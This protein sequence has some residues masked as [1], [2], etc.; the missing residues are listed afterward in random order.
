[1]IKFKLYVLLLLATFL[2]F[3]CSKYDDT[4][5]RKDV[6]D[7]Q[8]RVQ[9]LEK[10]C[11][12]ANGQIASLQGLVTALQNNDYVTGVTPVME[13]TEEVGYTLSFTQSKPI[14][15]M[16]GKNGKDG[17]TPII[18]VKMYTDN[19]YYW[20]IQTGNDKADWMKDDDGNMIPTTGKDG[21]AGQTPVLSV[22]K[23]GDRY[24]WQIDGEW[25]KDENGQKVPATGDKGDTGPAGSDGEQGAPGEKGDSFFESV[26]PDTSNGTVMIKLA[27][28]TEFTLPMLS[29]T[30]SFEAYTPLQI[31][32]AETKTA[33]IVKLPATIKKADFAAIKADITNLAGTNTAI[34]RTEAEKWT[35]ALT[36]PTFK[37]DGTLDAQPT[38]NVTVPATAVAGETALLEVAVVDTKGNKTSSTRV[39]YYDNNIAVTSVTLDPPTTIVKVGKTET[40]TATVTPANATNKKIIWTS[41]DAAVA[42]VAEGVVTG[43]KAGTATITATTEDGNFTA[44]CAVTVENIA[45]E[46]ISL[47]NTAIFLNEKKNI[48]YTIS[49]TDATVKTLIWSSSDPTIATVNTSTGEIEGKN[50]GDVTITATWT[51]DSRI[52]GTCTV[53]VTEKTGIVWATGNLV[54][55]GANGA[56]IGSPADGGLYFQFGSLIGWSGSANEDGTGI[57]G[58][59][60][61][62]VV[63]K[64]IGYAGSTDWGNTD[65][66]WQ[67]K[68]ATV[69]FT[70]AGSGSAEEIAGVG[71]PCRYYLKGNWRLPT[72]EDFVELFKE[73]GYPN[74]GPWKWNATT[75]SIYN[76]DGLTFP[77]SGNRNYVS[78]GLGTIG[79]SG[80]YWSATPLTSINNSSSLFFSN[81]NVNTSVSFERLNGLPIR[82]VQDK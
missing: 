48:A 56:K 81:T 28:G 82:C 72:K 20:T 1:M 30:V 18:G 79:I 53:M 43:V 29:T 8:S 55:D 59:L 27:N 47:T 54:A 61:L 3:G 64:P 22:A 23:D 16:H 46:S 44:T 36:A 80:R 34:T 9:Q 2:V 31:T 42:T 15:I 70:I 14:T 4:E 11:D 65:K 76:E 21:A 13:G 45:V 37:Q 41:S 71:D 6:N 73:K 49:P 66:I 57:G 10:W 52:K 50:A 75:K 68:T 25:L 26:T 38:V 77:A 67:S 62:S 17:I 78:G 63:V 35:V 12:I 60:A 19:Q 39:L 51:E 32:T 74:K 24:Y 69:P 7:L 33:V 5:L 40:M 58:N